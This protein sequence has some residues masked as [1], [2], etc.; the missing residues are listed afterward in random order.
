[1]EWMPDFFDKEFLRDTLLL[2]VGA[3]ITLI[4]VVAIPNLYQWWFGRENR[5]KI[6]EEQSELVRLQ[7]V[8]SELRKKRGTEIVIAKAHRGVVLSI[9]ERRVDAINEKYKPEFDDIEFQIKCVKDRI[10]SLK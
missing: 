4:V 9:I 5:K 2:I 7:N 10:R 6:R 1:M 3:L 8:Y